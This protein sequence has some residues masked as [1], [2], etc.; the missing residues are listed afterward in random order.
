MAIVIFSIRLIVSSVIQYLD[1][2][3]FEYLLATVLP[4]VIDLIKR[5]ISLSS[6]MLYLRL[7]SK[8]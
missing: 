2:E 7:Y 3:V 5:K 8:L 4:V 6:V 1:A